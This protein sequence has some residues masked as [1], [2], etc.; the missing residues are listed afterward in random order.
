MIDEVQKVPQIL[1]PI[2]QLIDK[3]VAK[4]IITGSSARKLMQQSEVNLL[5]GRVIS[6]KMT[7][8][9]YQENTDLNLDHHLYYGSLPE[10]CGVFSCARLFSQI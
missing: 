7:P 1:D 6:Y 4:F 3:K 5:P 10:I 8:L 9:S 2:Q